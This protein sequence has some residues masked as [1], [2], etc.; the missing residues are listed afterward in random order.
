[1]GPCRLQEGRSA[2][3]EWLFA[4]GLAPFALL[5]AGITHLGELGL[6][7][8]NAACRVH[9]LQLTGEE[10]VTRAANIYLQLRAYASHGVSSAATARYLAVMIVF[11]LDFFVHG[12]YAFNVMSAKH[13][14]GCGIGKTHCQGGERGRNL[15]VNKR[16][17]EQILGSRS[18]LAKCR[19]ISP[20]FLKAT[21]SGNPPLSHY[22]PALVF[23]PKQGV[24]KGITNYIG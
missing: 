11:G 4:L 15:C 23:H 5:Q 22:C 18:A 19:E 17:C 12:T 2:K 7:F 1:M 3:E 21:T 13:P 16:T 8:L 10:W 9:K 20:P 6:E 14:R 24:T